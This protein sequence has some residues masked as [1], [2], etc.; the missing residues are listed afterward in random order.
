MPIKGGM[1]VWFDVVVISFSFYETE[2][3]KRKRFPYRVYHQLAMIFKHQQQ[4]S[5]IIQ[6]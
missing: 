6:K 5:G 2:K 4:Y 3:G 1:V